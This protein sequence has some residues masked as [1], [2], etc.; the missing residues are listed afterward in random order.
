[1][2]YAYVERWALSE[3]KQKAVA[4][5]VSWLLRRLSVDVGRTLQLVYESHFHQVAN[6]HLRRPHRALLRLEGER[7]PHGLPIVDP[8]HWRVLQEV[9]EVALDFTNKRNVNG[10]S[11]ERDEFRICDLALL[12][13]PCIV[14]HLK[15][16]QHK[17]G[18]AVLG[19]LEFVTL[20]FVLIKLVKIAI[21][22]C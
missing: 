6:D 4:V 11:F 19:F 3:A 14:A 16:M 18:F 1:L 9:A 7:P 13:Q 10:L 12:S 20:L 21:C 2:C 22:K 15:F 5:T 17:Y 8:L